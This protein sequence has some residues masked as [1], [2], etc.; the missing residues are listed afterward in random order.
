L[1]YTCPPTP[2]QSYGIVSTLT[3][4][5][6]LP[7]FTFI[8]KES[9]LVTQLAVLALIDPARIVISAIPINYNQTQVTIGIL[10]AN[11]YNTSTQAS[12]RDACDLLVQQLNSGQLNGS[13]NL[14][15]VEYPVELSDETIIYNCNFEWQY[16]CNQPSVGL[17]TWMQAVLVVVLIVICLIF[18]YACCC[19]N[20]TL[21]FVYDKPTRARTQRDLDGVSEKK[22]PDMDG[23]SRKSELKR[24]NSSPASPSGNK[25]PNSPPSQLSPAQSK[26]EKKKET[27]QDTPQSGKREGVNTDGQWRNDDEAS[28]RSHNERDNLYVV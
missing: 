14:G 21:F 18:V 1:G 16:S 12:S 6:S 9:A 22:E 26:K 3:L 2:N 8:E 10:P 13:S 28:P 23:S 4:I 25:T 15:V 5:T 27:K 20:S 17:T 24:T 7:S 11:A 19:R